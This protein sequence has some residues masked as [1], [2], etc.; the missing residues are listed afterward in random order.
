MHTHADDCA[1][2]STQA[3]GRQNELK[4]TP[5][6]TVVNMN[7][8]A[9]PDSDD[10]ERGAASPAVLPVPEAAATS[11]LALIALAVGAVAS[12]VLWRRR[13]NRH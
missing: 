10:S 9:Q 7:E 13:A 8:P 2:A 11:P 4:W 1:L 6:S 12:V 5:S 3:L